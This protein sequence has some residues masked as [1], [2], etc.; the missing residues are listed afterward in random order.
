MLLKQFA[1]GPVAN[2]RILQLPDASG[3]GRRCQSYGYCGFLNR[4]ADRCDRRCFEAEFGSEAAIALVDPSAGKDERASGKG[5]SAGAFDHQ[6]LGRPAA[7]LPNED[8][9]RGGN[10]FV[11]HR[12]GHLHAADVLLVGLGRIG[13]VLGRSILLL[14]LVL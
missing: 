12:R 10:G 6:Q 5:H 9:S 14:N 13:H 7:R 1:K 4:L 11:V 2:E 3:I 8:E